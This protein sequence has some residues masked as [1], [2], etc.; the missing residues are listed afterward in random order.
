MVGINF[1]SHQPLEGS[2]I[3]HFGSLSKQAGRGEQLGIGVLY[4]EGLLEA[5]WVLFSCLVSALLIVI[6]IV[7]S[8]IAATKRDNC[9]LMGSFWNLSRCCFMKYVPL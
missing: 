3:E 8:R 6:P 4:V 7:K 2:G 1:L 5:A 9:E